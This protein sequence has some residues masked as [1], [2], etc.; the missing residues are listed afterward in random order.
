MP[1]VPAQPSGHVS[2]PVNK[3]TSQLA[4]AIQN[5]FSNSATILAVAHNK[6]TFAE[7]SL[8]QSVPSMQHLPT[9]F[10]SLTAQNS[11]VPV[12]KSEADVAMENLPSDEPAVSTI[13]ANVPVFMGSLR[14]PIH[15]PALPPVFEGADWRGPRGPADGIRMTMFGP[16]LI[17]S[18]RPFD[19]RPDGLRSFRPQLVRDADIRTTR[20]RLPSME[21][22]VRLEKKIAEIEHDLTNRERTKSIEHGNDMGM[23]MNLSTSRLHGVMDANSMRNI[24]HPES[25]NKERDGKIA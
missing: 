12:I 14:V 23:E 17:G 3:D 21:N 15:R 1:P 20:A 22:E 19:L 7:T 9:S 6:S 16:R 2:T 4:E 5:I 24:L 13:D 18:M 8:S 25:P 11:S 10:G